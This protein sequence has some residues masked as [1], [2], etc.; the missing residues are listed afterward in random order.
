LDTLFRR[1][2][3]ASLLSKSWTWNRSVGVGLWHI[4][5]R[6]QISVQPTRVAIWYIFI[7]K[8]QIWVN[9]VRPWKDKCWYIWL[10]IGI[11]YSHL[12]YFM[13]IRYFCGNLVLFFPRFW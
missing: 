10:I 2:Q 9:K 12:V 5:P 4:G 11:F 8:I 6:P 13:A 1:L 7:P 3:K